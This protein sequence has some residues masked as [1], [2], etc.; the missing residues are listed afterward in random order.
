MTTSQR[1]APLLEQYDWATERLLTRLAGPTYDSGDDRTIDAPA[2]T[3]A[4]YL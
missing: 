3:D 2:L 4:E 1:L